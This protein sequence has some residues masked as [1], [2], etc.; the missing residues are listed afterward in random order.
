M[1]ETIT[2]PEWPDDPHIV[3][4]ANCYDGWCGGSYPRPCNSTEG[5]TGLIHAAFGD[6]NSDGDYWLHT[7]CDV[8]GE[9]E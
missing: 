5:C 3:G 4:N 1:S 2:L 6:E 7:K 9:S 8:C